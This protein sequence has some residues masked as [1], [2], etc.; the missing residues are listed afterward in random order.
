MNGS[1]VKTMRDV[2]TEEIYTRMHDNEKIFFLSD[3]FGAPALD[4]LREKFKDRFINIGIAEQN[5]INISSGLALEG[6]IV[7]AYGIAPFITMRCYEQIRN[8]LSLLSQLKEI[9]VNLIGVGAGVSYDV[10]GPTHHCFE[11]IAMMRLLPNFVVFSPSDWKLTEKFIDYSLNV[12]KPKYI[13]LD[14]KPLP[15]IYDQ[16]Q[17]SDLENGFC[18]LNRGKEICIAS[19]GFM[20]HRAL[21]IANELKNE[22]SVGVIDLFL[23]KPVNED[24]LFDSLKKYEHIITL[25]EAFIGKGGLDSLISDILYS[26]EPNIKLKKV[27]FKDR[28]VFVTGSRD[29]LH[30]LNGLDEESIIRI[31]E[32]V[33]AKG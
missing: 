2:L 29:Y 3:D 5:L 11:D 8:N 16:I 15:Q 20:T 31:I 22:I 27:G 24:L 25:E 33:S 13:R 19:T 28:Y 30:K 4:K 7:Y 23:L 12:R 17:N 9:N 10:S 18:E 26:K 21:K 14:G 6:F 32:D 1:E